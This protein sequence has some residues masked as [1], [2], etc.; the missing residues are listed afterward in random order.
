[1]ELSERCI[2]TLEKEGFL[3]VYERQDKPGKVYLPHQHQDKV[4]IIVTEGSLELSIKGE[5]YSLRAGGRI[6][7]L[8]G[9]EHSATAG[10]SGCQYVV[11]EMVEGD[12]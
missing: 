4:T 10:L 3:H 1:M 7:I 8:P 11:G 2:Q 12:S 9:T 6:D 5:M